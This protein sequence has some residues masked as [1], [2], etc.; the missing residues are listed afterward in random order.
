MADNH[1][2]TMKWKVDISQMKAA[3]QDAK[4]SIQLANAEF[5]TATAGMDKWSNSA[6]GLEAK[7]KQ[8]NAT[9]PQQKAIL[10]QLENQYNLTAEN[11]GE[12]SAEAQRLKIQIENQRAT[13]AKTEASIGTYSNKLKEVKAS[14]TSL[15]QTIS[16]QERE[17]SGLKTAYVDAVAQYGKNSAEAKSLANQIST[18]S[19]ELAE[20]KA[21]Q[22]EA[23]KA[24]DKLDK[25]L[26]E[27]GDSAD[28]TEDD[29]R[30]LDSGFTVLKGTMANLAAQAITGLI[31]GFKKLG[32]AMIDVGKQAIMSYADYEQ[33]VGGVE[34]LFGA[35]G[36]TIEE[37]ANSVGKTVD[38]VRG[39][40][41][42]LMKAQSDVLANASTAFKTAGLSQNEYIETVT[43]FSAS[44]IQSLDGDTAKA[45]EVANRAIIDMSDNANKMGTSMTDIQNAYQGF[46]KQNYTMLDNLKLG[47]GGTQTE[48]A[49]LISDASKMKDVQKELGITVDESS[50]SFDN[51]VNAISVMQAS[52]GIAGT[53][54]E[55]AA[56]TISGS[57]NMTKAAWSNLLTGMA[58]DTAN[59]DQL[60]NDFVDSALAFGNNILPRIQTVITG[61]AKMV[62]GLV[63][64]L[65]PPILEQIPQII[66]ETLPMMVEAGESMISAFTSAFPEL[67]G[68]AV[69]VI[70]EMASSFT[71]QAPSLVAAGIQAIGALI[72][73]LASAAPDLIA[74]IPVLIMGVCDAILS[75]L[76]LLLDAAIQLFS[77]LASGLL[78]AIPEILSYIPVLIQQICDFITQ[79][80]PNLIQQG[81]LLV[82]SLIQ[83]LAEAIPIL[84]SYIPTL[85]QSIC[86]A[87]LPQIPLILDSGVTIMMSLL[88]GILSMLPM[89]IEYLPIIIDTICGVITE[90]LPM[91]VQ[92]GIDTLLKLIQG[93]TDAMPQLME[94]VPEIIRTIVQVL[95]DNLPMIV[96]MAIQIIVMLINGLT[97]ALPQLMRFVPQIVSTIVKVIIQNLPTILKAGVQIIGELISGLGSMLGAL[98]NQAAQIGLTILQKV[99]EIPAD[100]LK[101]GKN[102]VEGIWNGISNSLTWIKNKISGWVGNVTKFIK[103]LFGIGSP[104]KVMRDE[105][106]KWLPEGIALGFDNDMPFALADMKNSLNGA[107]GELKTDVA[108]QTSGIFGDVAVNGNGG[109]GGR[110]QIVNF[111]Q[112]INS[113]KA[114][115]RL[116]LYRETNSLLFSAKVRLNN[117]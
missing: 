39:E 88:D 34:T 10:A 99:G 42:N 23:S 104:S 43:G 116:T 84:V 73:G 110:N 19:G 17:L 52:M 111:N 114:V 92:A 45:A 41:D 95:S 97:E 66:T 9:L 11:M 117:V 6:T 8:L 71:E 74:Q 49:R 15:T 100:M 12:N 75:N 30:D 83:G 81:T 35:G 27:V 112:T 29:V 31:N 65:L 13:I 78:S 37:Y 38:E 94:Y 56:S 103:N 18:L 79:N 21:K 80:L 106:G 60:I 69:M 25:S 28:E 77:S 87:I 102:I 86:D 85:I 7:L 22:Q 109:S 33:L 64:N 54:A 55:E 76:P 67:I 62:T 32:S 101:A 20:N 115:D 16:D 93:L 63:Q 53:T 47:Y 48:M 44:L 2:S 70:T 4:R 57:L 89:L 36:Q 50:M 96:R 108:L 105:V 51:I 14:S 26:D 1:E 24:A 113:P 40:Y 5:K 82:I 3:M 68:M 59:F 98:A 107:L 91:I 72:Q 61:I 58:D 90:Y 46:A